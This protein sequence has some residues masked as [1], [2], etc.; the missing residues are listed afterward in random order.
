M[1]ATA[2]LVLFTVSLVGTRASFEAVGGANLEFE[3]SHSTL[4]LQQ[5]HVQG[6]LLALERSH[7]LL[8]SRVLGLLMRVVSLHF[9]LDLE[10]LIG[11]RLANI[12][13]LHS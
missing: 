2:I 4:Q 5:L 10:V 8:Y 12:L 6:S 3:L 9:L 7:L 1:R 13:R 11:Q